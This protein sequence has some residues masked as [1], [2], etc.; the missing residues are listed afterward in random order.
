[1]AMPDNSHGYIF[2]DTPNPP[3][4]NADPLVRLYLLSHGFA[5]A[6]SSY[7][8]TGWAIQDAFKDQIAVLDKFNQLV[9]QPDRT[10]AWG[11]S[12]GGIITAGLVQNHPDR[13]SG[14]LPF[15]GVLAGSVGVWNDWLD[16]AFA[17][18]TLLA[19]G[20]LQLV[21]ITDPET[22]LINAEQILSNAQN[23]A[24]GQARIAFG[25]GSSRFIGL[26]RSFLAAAL[27][28]M[29]RRVRG[30]PIRVAGAEL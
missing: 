4:D 26:D 19:G 6:G 22:N 1:M 29:L 24:Q 25:S 28:D 18:N 15:C 13:F 9:R 12:M 27:P 14:A 17:F 8:S 16:S 5:L 30:E 20:Q 11:H 10:V 3:W 2:P 21:N 7:A 23:T